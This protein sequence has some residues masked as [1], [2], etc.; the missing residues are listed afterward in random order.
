[1]RFPIRSEIASLHKILTK[2]VVALDSVHE[3][4]EIVIHLSKHSITL[5][6]SV[7]YI[8]S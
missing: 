3:F 4:E 7:I 5:L 1:V 6:M 2:R 8:L